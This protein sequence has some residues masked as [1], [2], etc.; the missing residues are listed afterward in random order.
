M[1]VFGFLKRKKYWHHKKNR[2]ANGLT[3]NI[4]SEQNYGHL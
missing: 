1:G 4:I 2:F 3:E